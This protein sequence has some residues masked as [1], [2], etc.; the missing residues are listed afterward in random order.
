MKNNISEADRFLAA[1][2]SNPKL[3]SCALEKPRARCNL[4]IKQHTLLAGR[5]HD[6]GDIEVWAIVYQRPLGSY[7]GM[8]VLISARRA[9]S[10]KAGSIGALL[11]KL[12]FNPLLASGPLDTFTETITLAAAMADVCDMV[13]RF[14]PNVGLGLDID[15]GDQPDLRCLIA[16]HDHRCH[17][18]DLQRQGEVVF[19]PTL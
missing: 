4:E 19:T 12:Q 17:A 6:Q 18:D 16:Y 9:A 11:G 1:V 14:D 8:L 15:I 2:T 5:I 7:V 13:E 3:K 10:L